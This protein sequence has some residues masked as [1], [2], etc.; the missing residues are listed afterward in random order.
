M[1]LLHQVCVPQDIELKKK[2]IAEAH[3]TLL[4]TAHPG[5]TKMYQDLRPT[6]WRE[7]MKKDKIDFVQRCLVCQQIKAEHQKSPGVLV[8]LSIPEWKWG[9]I[10]MDFVIGLPRTPQ[11][12][13]TIWVVVD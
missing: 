8:L 4:Y 3:C 7:E 1:R 12:Y 2:I 9:H 10:S 6:F 11:G 5:V 13:D